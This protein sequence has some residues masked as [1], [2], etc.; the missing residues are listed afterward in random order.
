MVSGGRHNL[1]ISKETTGKGKGMLQ[2]CRI[3]GVDPGRT[4]G[5]GDEGNDLDRSESAAFGVVRGNAGDD[6]K[7]CGDFVTLSNEEDGAALGI[8]EFLKR[9]EG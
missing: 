7:A 3:L 4:M 1:E 2:L 9:M 8:R 5:C 6:I